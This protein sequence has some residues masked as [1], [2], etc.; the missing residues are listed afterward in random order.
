MTIRTYVD[1]LIRG[2]Q[3]RRHADTPRDEQNRNF[4]H[5][6][7]RKPRQIWKIMTERPR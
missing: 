5:T 7:N 6:N 4:R 1:V 3:A 2:L